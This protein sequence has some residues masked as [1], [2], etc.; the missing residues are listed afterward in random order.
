[1]RCGKESP[2][3]EKHQTSLDNDFSKTTKYSSTLF[4]NH[5][6]V[7]IATE[8]KFKTSFPNNLKCSSTS[9]EDTEVRNASRF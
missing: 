8:K 5:R 3:P 6:D 1:M 7:I 4:Q 9:K 2:N